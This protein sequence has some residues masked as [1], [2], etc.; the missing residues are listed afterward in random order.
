MLVVIDANVICA[1]LLA[2]G[3]TADILF[4]GQIEPIGPERLVSEVDR[5]KEELLE[6]SKLSEEDFN[7][8][9]ALLRGKIR[10]VSAEEFRDFL[11]E[12]NELLRPHTKDTEYVALSLRFK[13][14]LWSKEKLLKRLAKVEVLD[15]DDVAKRIS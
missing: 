3:K 2:K 10:I 1:A 15:A 6:K 4:S 8:L 14:P 5:H 11:S 7:E 12:A 9:L 13:C